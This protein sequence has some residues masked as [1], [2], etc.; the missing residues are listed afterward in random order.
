MSLSCGIY[1]NRTGTRPNVQGIRQRPIFI[2]V[3]H[4]FQ[5]IITKLSIFLMEF[6]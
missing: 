6:L 3:F 5:P 4:L 1:H 2:L